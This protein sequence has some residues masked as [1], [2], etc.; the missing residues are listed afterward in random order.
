MVRV[1]EVMVRLNLL[2]RDGSW[3]VDR[4]A[5]PCQMGKINKFEIVG[6]GELHYCTLKTGI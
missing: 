5:R 2:K 4:G 6:F 1:R 3:V